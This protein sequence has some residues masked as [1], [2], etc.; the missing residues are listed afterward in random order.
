MGSDNLSAAWLVIALII[1]LGGAF[2]LFALIKARRSR[3]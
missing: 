3:P 1:L 2:E